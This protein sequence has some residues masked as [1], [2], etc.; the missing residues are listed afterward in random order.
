MRVPMTLIKPFFL[1]ILSSFILVACSSGNQLTRQH[2]SGPTMGTQYNISVFVTNQVDINA[3]HSGIIERLKEVNAI[4][5]TYIQDSELSRLNQYALKQTRYPIKVSISKELQYLLNSSKKVY[6]QSSG[7]FD[8]S[9]GPLVNRW[10]F[11]PDDKNG[12]PSAQEIKTLKTT[13]GQD[14]LSIDENSISLAAKRKLDLSA[15]AK[16]WG[17]DVVGEYLEQN[18]VDAYL[19]DI[20]GEVRAKGKK[21]SNEPWRV[22]IERPSSSP[23]ASQRAQLILNL[24]NQSLATSGDYRNYFE[25]KG[26]RYSHTIDP[27]TGYPITHGLASVS[28]VYENCTFAD[29][30]ATAIN[31]MGPKKGM[32]FAIKHNLAVYLIVRVGET[33]EE[34]YSPLFKSQFLSPK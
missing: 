26:R 25:D 15:I 13:V 12:V 27:K 20:G 4:A 1:F 34:H 3:L 5:S 22:A 21:P 19:V 31:V 17:V 7:A 24:N 33:F 30:Y 28:V 8:I 18:G 23:T 6:E 9:V 10:G 16:G 11:G 29:A 14:S 2:L 32:E